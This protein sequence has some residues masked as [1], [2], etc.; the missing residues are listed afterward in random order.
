MFKYSSIILVYLGELPI[1]MTRKITAL[2]RKV[3]NDCGIPSA[4]FFWS[5]FL[6]MSLTVVLLMFSTVTFDNVFK[7]NYI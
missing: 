5:I 1:G 4:K 7:T 2:L 3:K 6:S